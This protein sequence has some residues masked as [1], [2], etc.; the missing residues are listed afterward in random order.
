[1]T[2]AAKNCFSA[3]YA[4]ARAQ[5]LRSAGETGGVLSAHTHPTARGL[6]GEPLQIDVAAFGRRGASKV[7]LVVSGTHGMEG[8]A[9]SAAQIAFIQSGRLQALPPDLMV[10]MVHALNAWGFAHGSR[11]NVDLNRN[12]IDWR[13]PP[14]SWYATAER[15]PR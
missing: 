7:F 12:F 15:G 13:S 6:A 5:F 1:M 9:G 4:E 8:Y 11:T 3:S 14:I 10:V 2:L